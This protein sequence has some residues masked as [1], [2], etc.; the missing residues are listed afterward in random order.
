MYRAAFIS[1]SRIAAG[2]FLLG[3]AGLQAQA[4][5][6]F[7]RPGDNYIAL[8]AEWADPLNQTGT[9]WRIIDTA[10]PYQHPNWG[11]PN[12]YPKT[13]YLLPASTNASGNAAI[14]ANFGQVQTSIAIYK[15]YFTTPGTYRWY[16]R[17][18]AFE[19]GVDP[20]GYGSEDSMFRPDSFDAYPN[21]A[22]H[23]YSGQAEGQYGWRN[24][25][26]GYTVSA[27][28]L[29]EFR[30][31]PRENGFSIDRMVFSLATALSST[32]LDG[33]AN[34][35]V[36]SQTPT[37]TEF[38][39]GGGDGRWETADNWTGGVPTANSLAYIGN[40]HTVSLSQAG[41][42]A[43][44]LWI[45][46]NSSG[47]S[48]PGN[49]T[50]QQTAGDLTV[51][52][53]LAIGVDGA[54]GNYTA[55]GGTLTIGS[56]TGRANFYIARSTAEITNNPQSTVDL[57]GAS[58][59]TAYLDQWIIGQRVGG[60]D[61]N[62]GKP[63]AQVKLAQTNTIDARTILISQY[64][65]WSANPQQTRLRLGQ[66]NTIKTDLLT[67]AGSRGN[68]LLDFLSSGST[69]TLQGSTGL[70]A[71]LWIASC[72]I[73]T[74]NTTTG[75]M[76][77]TA[78]V[79]NAQLD[80]LV[81][82]YRVGRN[83][84]TTTSTGVLSFHAGTVS[85]NSIILGQGTVAADGNLGQGIGTL[86]MGGGTLTVAG[87]IQ[88]GIGTSV[89]QGTLNLT[90][91]TL[92]VQGGI[93]GGVGTSTVSIDGPATVSV[94]GN[95]EVRN[96]WVGGNGR[97]SNPT[98]NVA[99]NFT[100]LGGGS[101]RV[102]YRNSSSI[103]PSNPTAGTLDLRNLASPAV[104]IAASAI[105]V[106]LLTVDLNQSVEGTVWLPTNRPVSI[107]AA[108]ITIGHSTAGYTPTVKGTVHLGQQTTIETSTMYVGRNKAQGYMDIASGGTLTLT[109]PSGGKAILRVGYQDS[110]T[111]ADIARGT[112]DLTGG[113][114]NANL[115]ELTIGYHL[116]PW[117]G[118]AG[119]VE[120]VMTME[121][122][123]VTADTVT[124]GY[125]Q[126]PQGGAVAG[127]G[128]IGTLNLKGGNFQAQTI[129][130]SVG[131]SDRAKGTLNFSGGVLSA[132]QILKGA[133]G[134]ASFNWT[135][136]TLHVD[137]FG[138]ASVAFD[139]TQQGGL[140]A[141]GRS[142]GSTTIYGNY[143]QAPAG[144]LEIELASPT[145]YDTVIVHGQADLQG[146][147]LVKFLGGYA[148]GLGDTFHIVYASGGIDMTN[149]VLAGDEPPNSRWL[150][151]VI[152]GEGP[153]ENWQILQ[154][155][156][157]VPEP[158]SGLLALLAGLAWLGYAGRKR[159]PSAG[160]GT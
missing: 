24:S 60:S 148:P 112:L 73:A 81:I 74:G 19:D 87:N 124:I 146:T 83:Q 63:Y 132:E 30:I 75:T 142:I 140:L 138:T 49:G 152:P 8:E 93:L 64:D 131:G 79:F 2:L 11:V 35:V 134:T 145:S 46:H 135:G 18:S 44:S 16:L 15:I 25:G 85:A 59:F 71:D 115:S 117:S 36:I 127:E 149:L 133:T 105:E 92:T 48:Y 123:T 160:C 12:R 50:L 139:L 70:L 106:G 159:F 26:V 97:T 20:S 54:T 150:L 126:P 3:F 61:P 27:P 91:G 157:A 31:R 39:N 125:G 41:A 56:A 51:G 72:T 40:N 78:G 55:S 100:L 128:G 95:L 151:D 17:D 57:S 58:E 45:G 116:Y 155:Q 111:G 156:A 14:L 94:Q 65:I 84:Y 136:G 62:Y 7:Q 32:Q 102:G 43:L 143:T 22:Y 88:M 82:G 108:T 104:S 5:I 96:F 144:T 1:C 68:A 33:L 120:A 86:N 4:G 23:G 107:S 121:A 158:A 10:N 52:A 137:T 6:I 42:A 53:L 130:L 147:L 28:G 69:L 13:Q 89:S 141:P 99:G 110:T 80:E 9:D 77:L 101:L 109:G 119:K 66:S 38:T 67:V 129:Q 118:T 47:T 34:S 114:F 98:V 21:T 103:N 153:W 29:V 76:D 154:L 122:G 113:T 90:G 37:V